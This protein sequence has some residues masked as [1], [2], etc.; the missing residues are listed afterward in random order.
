MVRKYKIGFFAFFTTI[1]VLTTSC[2]KTQETI[3]VSIT[4]NL[5]E[6]FDGF[7]NKFHNDSAFQ[8]SRVRFPL[9]GYK[10]DSDGKENWRPDN[11]GV[12]KSKIYDVDTSEFKVAYKKNDTLFWE[13]C[14][15]E[16]SG[17]FS[18]YQFELIN[19][20]WFLVYALD[21]NL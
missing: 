13:K 15:L 3:Q 6:D 12:L 14:W 11:W 10:V 2:N 20:K 19:K 5:E 9:E 7:Y 8:M 1:I 4:D 21:Q 17:F 16:D 18:E